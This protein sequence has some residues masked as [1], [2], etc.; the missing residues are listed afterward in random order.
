MSHYLAHFATLADVRRHFETTCGYSYAVNHSVHVWMREGVVTAIAKKHKGNKSVQTFTLLQRYNVARLG[1][2]QLSPPSSNELDGRSDC[3]ILEIRPSA[4]KKE[5]DCL[6]SEL[7]ENFVP[8]TNDP[9][10]VLS[11]RLFNNMSEITQINPARCPALESALRFLEMISARVTQQ[12]QLSP[13]A[14][15]KRSKANESNRIQE[16]QQRQS[17]RLQDKRDDEKKPLRKSC[18]KKSNEVKPKSQS[19]VKAKSKKTFSAKPMK[20]TEPSLSS[21][22]EDDDFDTWTVADLKIYLRDAGLSPN[23]NKAELVLRAS[24]S[25]CA[26]VVKKEESPKLEKRER[27]VEIAPKPQDSITV[28]KAR[29]SEAQ[30]KEILDAHVHVIDSLLDHI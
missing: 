4:H 22:E 20:P 19:K 10:Y 29:L 24:E 23:G 30:M 14:K 28:K 8:L 7:A 21:E 12:Q 6:L 25:A 26:A 9:F 13:Q 18:G 3:V 1:M 15:V 11:A 5:Y 16:Q 17:A 2:F 27:P